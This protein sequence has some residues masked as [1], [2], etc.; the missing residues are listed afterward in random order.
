MSQRNYS[1]QQQRV[2][3]LDSFDKTI[4]NAGFYT[5]DKGS[6]FIKPF[7]HA[8]ME[9]LI[10]TGIC[11]EKMLDGFYSLVEDMPDLGSEIF[12]NCKKKC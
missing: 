5:L 10:E 6:Y 3:D 7:T 4:S 9:K 1:L 8:Q 12:I 11:D 2:F